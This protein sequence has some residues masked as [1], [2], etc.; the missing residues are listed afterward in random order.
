MSKK[1]VLLINLGTPDEPSRAAVYR[2]LKEFLLDPRVIDI[3]TIP[4]HL[5]VRGIIAPFRSKTSA[6]IYQLLWT[7]EGSP[8]KI[9]GYQLQEL[10]Q[11]EIGDGYLVELAMRYQNPPLE[12]VLK[13]MLQDNVSELIIVP[14]FPHYASAS[15]GSVYEEVMRILSKEWGI[16]PLRFVGAFYD[17]PDFIAAFV[18]RTLEH[19]INSF[20]HILFSYHGLPVRQMVKADRNN[21]C[22]KTEDCCLTLTD[23]NQHCYSA[24]C[25]ATTKAL[26]KALD[27]KEGQY[28]SCFQSRLGKEPWIEPF[29]P[30]I[31]EQ[32]AAKGDKKILCL[33]PAFIADCLE[34]TVEISLEYQKLFEGFGGEKLQLVESLNNHPIWV[35]G[36]K[37]IITNY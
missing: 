23:K 29:T 9:Y 8:L 37:N 13:K 24:Q 20:D 14:L 7:K 16:P 27:L 32:R 22:Q 2:Y 3:G 6:E 11:K 1:G 35:K 12:K 33:C 15:T 25:Y 19:D 26:V 36:L 30:K 10:L 4:R 34:T 28:T 18:A 5:L 31:I 17:H 21:H